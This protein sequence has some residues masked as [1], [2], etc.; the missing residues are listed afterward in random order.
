M[1]EVPIS[2]VWSP[3]NSY[4]RAFEDALEGATRF[5]W[6]TS[7][8]SSAGVDLMVRSIRAVLDRKGRGRV[9]VAIDRGGVNTVSAFEALLR[10]KDDYELFELHAAPAGPGAP[11]REGVA[12]RGTARAPARRWVGQPD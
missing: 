11:P 9:V 3:D 5:V 7:F 2:L 12:C 1:G 4:L 10:L 8:F 6:V